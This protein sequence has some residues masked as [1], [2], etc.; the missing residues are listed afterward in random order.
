MRTFVG[1]AAG[2]LMAWLAGAPLLAGWTPGE[3]VLVSWTLSPGE[4]EALEAIRADGATR[5]AALA[6]GLSGAD[7]ADE[8]V[9]QERIVAEKRETERRFL[10]RL[11][12]AAQERGDLATAREAEGRLRTLE[13]SGEPE[14]P[15]DPGRVEPKRR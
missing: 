4:R 12:D 10:T 6:S 11:R 8:A 5:I 7:E 13:G 14:A 2:S 3:A 15:A 1:F 9:L